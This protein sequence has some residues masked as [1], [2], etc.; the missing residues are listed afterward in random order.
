MERD[1]P[2]GNKGAAASGV[3]HH[4]TLLGK[5]IE[6]E[7]K[8]HYQYYQLAADIAQIKCPLA[9]SAGFFLKL[10]DKARTDAGLVMDLLLRQ[11]GS[12]RLPGIDRPCVNLAIESSGDATLSAA[13]EACLQIEEAKERPRFERL[14]RESGDVEVEKLAEELLLEHRRLGQ[15]LRRHLTVSNQLKENAS[16]LVYA[17]HIFL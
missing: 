13:L 1:E 12:V 5:Q 7:L 3:C 9:G 4:G 8:A 10:A 2:P 6:L 16:S 17:S 14:A 11:G 15:F